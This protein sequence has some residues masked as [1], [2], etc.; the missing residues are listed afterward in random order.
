M[1]GLDSHADSLEIRA[2]TGYLPGDLALPGRL[3][4]HEVLDWCASLR[5]GSPPVRRDELVERFSVQLDRPVR[6]LSRATARSSAWC[7]RSSTTP[8]W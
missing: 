7:R 8:S 2:R 3:T 6:R 5:P 4:G 1:L